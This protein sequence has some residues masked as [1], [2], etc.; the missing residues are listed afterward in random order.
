[1][2]TSLLRCHCI[3]ALY[4]VLIDKY[5]IWILSLGLLAI[6]A[7]WNLDSLRTALLGPRHTVYGTMDRR[8]AGA[9]RATRIRAR[10][11]VPRRPTAAECARRERP[12]T[13]PV[14][15]SD[16]GF[17]L[18]SRS[19]DR[20][21]RRALQL[22]S[23][24]LGP[25]SPLIIQAHMANPADIAQ[26]TIMAPAHSGLGLHILV[27]RA[28]DVLES[29]SSSIYN[30]GFMANGE[31]HKNEGF[32]EELK[33]M[34]ERTN[35]EDSERHMNIQDMNREIVARIRI[36]YFKSA[37][38]A[39]S[40]PDRCTAVRSSAARAAPRTAADAAEHT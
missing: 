6:L 7:D 21:R 36:I 35:F 1:M 28:S 8:S 39:P 19:H 30:G 33:S 13:L 31:T 14:E 22:L 25:T 4:I 15:P 12:E 24:L 27:L 3:P 29:T 10:K 23:A 37:K 9:E 20:P 11:M 16:R 40:V 34:W 2:S 26:E 38:L 18:P 5:M 17:S 32:H